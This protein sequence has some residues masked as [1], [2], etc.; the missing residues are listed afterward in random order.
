MS[1]ILQAKCVNGELVLDEKLSADL[2]GKNLKIR[3]VEVVNEDEDEE[4]RKEK[5]KRFL[6]KVDQHSFSLPEDYKF[7]R[8]ELYDR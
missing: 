2:E 6:E 8:D 7:N 4:T 5:A 1:Q 3:I